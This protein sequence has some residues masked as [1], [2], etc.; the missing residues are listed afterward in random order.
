MHSVDFNTL[1]EIGSV[2]HKKI[3]ENELG[4]ARVRPDRLPKQHQ[5]LQRRHPHHVHQIHLLGFQDALVNQ[6]LVF[7]ADRPF[8]EVTGRG[9][10]DVVV[11]QFQHLGIGGEIAHRPEEDVVLRLGVVQFLGNGFRGVV[12]V[13]HR[14]LRIQAAGEDDFQHHQVFVAVRGCLV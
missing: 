5:R 4:H 7:S 11:V 3:V 6:H 13:F 12:F 9:N 10:L 2:H 1:A 8:A 14:D